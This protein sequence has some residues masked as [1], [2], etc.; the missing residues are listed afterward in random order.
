MQLL[1]WNLGIKI[2]NTNKVIEFIKE[3][4]FDI[5][6][7]QEALKARDEKAY[8]MYRT[9]NDIENTFHADYSFNA[10][11]P[12]WGAKEIMKNGKISRDFGGF[13]EQGSFILSKYEILEHYNQF[14]HKE[15]IE[16]GFDAT[17]FKKNDHAR[18][19]Q[20]AILGINNNKLQIINIHGIWNDGKLG[21]DRTLHQC[22]FII[23][24]VLEND[25]PTVIL[26]DFNL[27]PNSESIKLLNNHFRNLVTENNIKTTRPNFDDGL[28]KGNIVCDYIFVNDKIKVNDFKV[29]DNNISDHMPLILDFDIE[30]ELCE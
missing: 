17:Y 12:V 8:N 16:P 6:A 2:D 9:K 15:Y 24:K 19:I 13:V 7:F 14:Y 21:D 10:F 25:Y 23:D 18:S 27:L 28:D 29:L 26:G 5:L 1:C 4:N 3:R 30:G 22:Q 20:N 11:A